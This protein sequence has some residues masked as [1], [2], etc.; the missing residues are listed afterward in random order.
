MAEGRA[1]ESYK[2]YPDIED[3]S[4]PVLQVPSGVHSPLIRSYKFT[5]FDLIIIV[6]CRLQLLHPDM[7]KLSLKSATHFFKREDKSFL[8]WNQIQYMNEWITSLYSS[9]SGV[10]KTSGSE[11]MH[12][13]STGIFFCSEVEICPLS[14]AHISMALAY[15][16][17]PKS[18]FRNPNLFDFP[19][20]LL[21]QGYCCVYWESI[22]FWLWLL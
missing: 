10:R 1:E 6:D 19:E 18:C 3:L 5:S 20:F 7:F 4:V 21:K 11:Q 8:L 14:S 16:V 15:T 2:K 12:E 22:D 17:T 9:Q 13:W